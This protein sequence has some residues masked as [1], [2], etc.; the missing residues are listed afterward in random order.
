MPFLIHFFFLCFYQPETQHKP[1]SL[2][3][4]DSPSLM[5]G[6]KILL[7]ILVFAIMLGLAFWWCRRGKKKHVTVEPE[8]PCADTGTDVILLHRYPVKNY[9]IRKHSFVFV[10]S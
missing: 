7:G 8:D 4:S 6:I 3:D 9:R 1:T 10:T 5:E 2:F